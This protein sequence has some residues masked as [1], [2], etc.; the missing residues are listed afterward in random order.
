MRRD[1]TRRRAAVVA[2]LS[3]FLGSALTV[4]LLATGQHSLAGWGLPS[5]R[6]HSWRA[7]ERKVRFKPV[8]ATGGIIQ[9]ELLD[10][11]QVAATLDGSV[12]LTVR[13]MY[14]IIFMVL[15]MWRLPN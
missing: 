12:L 4:A 15:A 2:L 9:P 1:L 6:S 11:V 5:L 3:C 13:L 14:L 10:A 7:V 8:N